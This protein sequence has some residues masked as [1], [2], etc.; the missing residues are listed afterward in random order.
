[1]YQERTYRNFIKSPELV[2]YRVVVKETDLMV[3][4]ATRLIDEAKE[5]VLEQRGYLE[6][7]IQ[8]HPDFAGALVPWQLDGPA[9][10]IILDMIQAGRTAGVGPMA[11]VAGAIAE[12]VGTGLLELTDQVIVENGGDVFIKT[13]STL[14]VG[15]FAGNSPLSLRIGI[16]LKDSSNPLAVCTSSGT[17]GH[18]LSLGKADAVCVVADSC[19]IADA[20]AT[21]I[22]NLVDSPADI[23]NAIGVGREMNALIGVVVVVEDKVGMW[24]DLEIVWLQETNQAL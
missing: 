18:S 2:P 16:R 22:G 3:Y 24:G 15:I 13:N 5:L 19:S 12:Q 20:A 23:D 1:M 9:P 7:F 6:A 17:I 21:S 14:T 11:A 8:S 10:A 4:T